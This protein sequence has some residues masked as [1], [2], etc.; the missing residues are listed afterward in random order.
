MNK[1]FNESSVSVQANLL[2]QVKSQGDGRSQ[3]VCARNMSL[4]MRELFVSVQANLL[5]QVKSQ[6]DGCSPNAYMKAMNFELLNCR[7]PMYRA[8]DIEKNRAA[9]CAPTWGVEVING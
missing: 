2:Q 9:S 4:A 1:H 3:N 8:I 5:Q 7:S 6:R